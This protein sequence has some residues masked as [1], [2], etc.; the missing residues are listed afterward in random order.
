M[1]V[2]KN[3]SIRVRETVANIIAKDIKFLDYVLIIRLDDKMYVTLKDA[4]ILRD[5]VGID[6][7]KKEVDTLY[8]K[9]RDLDTI[10]PKIIRKGFRVAIMDNLA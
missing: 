9:F 1:E 5:I 7:L 6:S 10:L 4:Y 3:S 8:F 2:K